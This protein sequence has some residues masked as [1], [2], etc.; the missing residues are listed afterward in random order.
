MTIVASSRLK[1]IREWRGMSKS[2]LGRRAGVTYQTIL[3]IESG[4][5]KP[6]F[7]VMVKIAQALDVDLNRLV[8]EELL[9]D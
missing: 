8:D 2:E 5:N 9:E 3:N 1:E 4:R 6:S 7:D